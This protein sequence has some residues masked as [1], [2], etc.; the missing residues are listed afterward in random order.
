MARTSRGAPRRPL[1]QHRHLRRGALP[2][3]L[4]LPLQAATAP[5]WRS[6]SR[7]TPG[8]RTVDDTAAGSQM[9]PSTG[10]C[11]GP[12]TPVARS[13]ARRSPTCTSA[14]PTSTRPTRSSASRCS[15]T[16]ACV[17]GAAA[18]QQAVSHINYTFNWLY[19]DSSTSPTTLGRVTRSGPRT[20]PDFPISAP[21]RSTG[22][23]STRTQH[24]RLPA[25]R[26]HPQAVDPGYIVSWNN[27][28]APDWAAADDKYDYGP[29]QRQQMIADK[30][31]A[32]TKGG[33]R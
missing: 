11:T 30:V 15:T 16:R 33:R 8:R 6:S 20:S 4:P 2:G 25:L 5:P 26:K 1:G 27:K 24:R 13:A 14:A 12:S 7:A 9:L 22:A 18:F 21:A 19:A 23:V 10:P 32:A 28:Q 31:S 3:R 17:T 29:V